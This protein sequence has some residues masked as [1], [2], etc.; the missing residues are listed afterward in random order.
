MLRRIECQYEGDG[1]RH[2]NLDDLVETPAGRICTRESYAE[3]LKQC[4]A[5]LEPPLLEEGFAAI[6]EN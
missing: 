4:F 5:A 1:R 3:A 2:I 6:Q